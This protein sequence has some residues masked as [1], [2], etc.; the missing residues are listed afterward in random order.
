MIKPIM[1]S[2]HPEY[3]YTKEFYLSLCGTVYEYKDK[4]GDKYLL[5]PTCI[6][7]TDF[8]PTEKA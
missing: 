8:K 2:T 7:R 4:N 3:E 5:D 6:M 1:K